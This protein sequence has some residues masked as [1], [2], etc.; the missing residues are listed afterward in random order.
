M[1]K[2]A[3]GREGLVT[4]AIGLG[5]MGMSQAYG[6]H[7]DEQSRATIARALDLG[8]CFLDTADAYGQGHNERLVGEAIRRRRDEVVVATKF[9]I[10]R[11]G[12]MAQG[13]CG[14]PDYVI[15]SCDASLARLGTDHIDL[16]YL[17]RVDPEVPIEETVGAMAELVVA[18]KVRFLGLSEASSDSLRRA[19]LVHPI[20]ALQSEWSMWTRDL[21]D[22]VLPTAR[23]LGIGIVPY[24]PLGRGFLTGQVRSREMLGGDDFRAGQ[25]R[26][27]EGNLE[28]NLERVEGVIG[29]ARSKGVTPAQ[30]ALAWLLAQGD[31]VV[32]IPGTKR[33]SALEENAAAAAVD[34]SDQDLAELA[35]LVPK[36]AFAGS[37]YPDPDYQYGSSPAPSGTGSAAGEGA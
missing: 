35:R 37:R 12:T 9:G 16:Y 18:G 4:S 5:C 10:L 29:L 7:D 3:L 26:F 13:V 22:E 19:A 21:E 8:V 34:L 30:L 28:R 23:S 2:R 24:S 36:G 33:R 6:P 15:S 31:D 32:P 27:Q 25:P 1:P 20:S 11:D 14:R 17:H